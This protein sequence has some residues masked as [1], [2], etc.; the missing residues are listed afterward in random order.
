MEEEK[1]SYR[2]LWAVIPA[3]VAV[4]ALAICRKLFWPQTT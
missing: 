3:I 1:R 4:I 2:W